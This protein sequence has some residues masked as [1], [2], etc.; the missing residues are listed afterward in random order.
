[1]ILLKFNFEFLSRMPQQRR[2][3]VKQ[4]KGPKSKNSKKSA[5]DEVVADSSFSPLKNNELSKSDFFK[6]ENQPS[7]QAS[8]NGLKMPTPTSATFKQ[9]T[10]SSKFNFANVAKISSTENSQLDTTN[11]Q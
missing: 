2:R 3:V 4:A 7:D 8:L 10:L 1:M 11:F 5:T 9:T 6:K